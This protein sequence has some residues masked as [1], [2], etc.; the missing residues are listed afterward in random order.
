[1]MPTVNDNSRLQLDALD[2]NTETAVSGAWTIVSKDDLH[3]M[4]IHCV[5]CDEDFTWTTGEQVFFRDKGLQN[6]PK[7]CKPC[8]QK[9]NERLDAILTAQATGIKQKVEVAVN[10]ARCNE[11]TTVPFYPSQGRPVFCRSCFLTMQPAKHDGGGS[12]NQVH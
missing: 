11:M 2:A 9:K 3:D 5:D 8:K 1:M 10:C 4:T 6:P 12:T 7:R